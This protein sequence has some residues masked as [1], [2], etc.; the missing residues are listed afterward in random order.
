MA[1]GD[2]GA[3]AFVE[4]PPVWRGPVPADEEWTAPYWDAIRRHELSVQRCVRCV[5]WHHPPVLVCP[6]CSSDDLEFVAVAG[7]GTVYASTVCHREF[8]LQIGVPWVAAY[9]ELDE[10]ARLATNLVNCSSEGMPIGAS[11]RVVYQDYPDLELT[12][13]FFEPA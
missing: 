9:V 2:P 4:I 7:T 5:S 13:A 8:G 3:G 11:V 6:H 1:R 12:L 10:G